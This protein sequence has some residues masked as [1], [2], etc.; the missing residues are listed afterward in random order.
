MILGIGIAHAANWH[1]F[2]GFL[3]TSLGITLGITLDR[4]WQLRTARLFRSTF[5]P[6][7]DLL[8]VYTDSPHW[9]PY[10]EENWLSRWHHRA[11]FFNRSKPWHRRQLEARLWRAATHY[12]D[13]TPVAILV[14]KTGRLLVFPFFQ[15]F[16]DSK[17]GRKHALEKAE[18]TLKAALEKNS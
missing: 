5:G 15:P 13:H 18:A 6:E 4:L 1:L 8:I 12:R 14:G 2:A 7:K 3:L 11:V 9:A 16:R 10:I 17:H